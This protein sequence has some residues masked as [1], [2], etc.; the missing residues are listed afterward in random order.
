MHY[1]E[2]DF[3]E[4]ALQQMNIKILKRDGKHFELENDFQIEV[5]RRDLYRLSN[6]GWVISPFDDVGRLCSFLKAN[7]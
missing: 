6:A 1:D 2:A 4:Y 7:M 5:E 3:L